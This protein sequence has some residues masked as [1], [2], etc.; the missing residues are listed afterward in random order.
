MSVASLEC[1]VAGPVHRL[2]HR[3]TTL[4]GGTAT[5]SSKNKQRAVLENTARLQNAQNLT[6]SAYFAPV[7][8]EPANIRRPRATSRLSCPGL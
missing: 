5:R 1:T 4:D 8:R 7:S 3:Q 2:P 6:F